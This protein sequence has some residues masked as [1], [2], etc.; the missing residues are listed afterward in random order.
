[1]IRYRLDFAG[2][3]Q[4][5]LEVTATI[6]ADGLGTIE[7]FL[8]TWTPGSYLIRE[9]ARHLEQIRLLHGSAKRLDRLSK[10]RWR[11]SCASS[12]EV[13][14]SYRI[15]ARELTV[16]TNFVDNDLALINGAAT[17]L[18]RPDQLGC[19]H[20]VVLEPTPQWSSVATSLREVPGAGRTFQAADYHE[21][22]DSPLLLG[23]LDRQS[24]SAAGRPLELVSVGDLQRWNLPQ[25]A[26]D[27]QRIVET[28]H[29][30]WGD[31]P[32][33]RY[34]FLNLVLEGFGG[35]EHDN[36]C[37]LLTTRG[38]MRD[39]ERYREWLELVCHEFFH[40]WNVRRLRPMALQAYDYEQETLLPELWV[41]EGMT[42]YYDQLLL[43]RSGLFSET[44]YLQALSK[45]IKGVQEAPGRTVQSVADASREAWIKFYRP[46]ENSTNSRISYYTKGALIA[47]LLDAALRRT[48]DDRH[49]LDDV[50]RRLW[51][52][53]QPT[54][55]RQQDVLILVSELA[56]VDVASQLERWIEGC[57]ELDFQ[58]AL[59]WWGLRWAVEP[60]A[61]AQAT[62]PVSNPPGSAPPKAWLGWEL[63]EPAGRVV[64]KR[65]LRDGPAARGGLQVDDEL[66]AVDG[67][68]AE[69][70]KVADQL[71]H[72]WDGAPVRV[73]VARRGRIRDCEVTPTGEPTASWRLEPDPEASSSS[74]QHRLAWLG[75]NG[76]QSR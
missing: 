1:M 15:Y 10:N 38:A 31:V 37:V 58:P 19:P 75:N 59:D 49:S 24:F 67:L 9:Y 54:G 29:Q 20:Q 73:T 72:V 74:Q 11:V 63:A 36:C 64:I 12:P 40:T 6:P 35:L 47:W 14:V 16:R 25:A 51:R 71:Q 57:D 28:E 39:P 42:S 53:H 46:D 66:I 69:P 45:T 56:G 8:P 3:R 52:Q 7:L 60:A 76:N 2:Y 5:Y 55:Y 34:L 44:D 26:S 50:M 70:G 17:F 62:S 43:A 65:I 30:F 41:A 27:V 68:R 61:T 21:L 13:V 32:Y 4:H 18:T 23:D 48:T 33:D 22:V